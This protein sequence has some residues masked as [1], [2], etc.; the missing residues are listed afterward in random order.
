M[1]QKTGLIII[2]IIIVG[3]AANYF[4]KS[5]VGVSS[6]NSQKPSGDNGII[7]PKIDS[8]SILALVESSGAKEIVSLDG[9]GKSKTFYT[10]KNES[11]KIKKV[12]SVTASSQEILVV[13]GNNQ[14]VSVQ[15]DGTG[16]KTVYNSSFVLPLDFVQSPDT[17][18][19][20]YL[21]FSN[22]EREYGYSLYLADSNGK[23]PRLITR[24]NQIIP[25]LAWLDNN[26]LIFA[27]NIEENSTTRSIL[28]K[29]NVTSKAVE[30]VYSSTDEINSIYYDNDQIT[31]NQSNT[32]TDQNTVIMLDK[33]GK[34]IK[35]VYTKKGG[36]LYYPR[37]S[38]AKN[39][40]AYLLVSEVSN[41]LS[42][43]IYLTDIKASTNQKVT[44]AIKLL[45][46]I[47]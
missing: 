33:T 16:K 41:N 40:L 45:S 31:L 35:K 36:R 15:L 13:E 20:A 6:K 42:G 4:S 26:N 11:S 38:Q 7:N 30:E 17:N 34:N 10:D 39:K 44:S 25:E 18:K 12:S 46:W 1:K 3:F 27:Q 23:N 8:G 14:L 19:I 21:T 32:D 2:F 5:F 37:Y 28:N 9:N 29:I 22:A 24:Q 43:D 47:P